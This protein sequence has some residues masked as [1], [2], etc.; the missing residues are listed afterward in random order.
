MPKMRVIFLRRS[1]ALLLAL[2]LSAPDAA[3]ALRAVEPSEDSR[4][5]SGMEEA[6]A[7]GRAKYLG[8]IPPDPTLLLQLKSRPSADIKRNSSWFLKALGGLDAWLGQVDGDRWGKYIGDLLQAWVEDG[9]T[10]VEGYQ[11]ASSAWDLQNKDRRFAK[12]PYAPADAER[13]RTEWRRRETVAT[14]LHDRFSIAGRLLDEAHASLT[15]AM[16]DPNQAILYFLPFRELQNQVADQHLVAFEDEQGIYIHAGFVDFVLDQFKENSREG[17]RMLAALLGHAGIERVLLQAQA[18]PDVSHALA[19]GLERLLLDEPLPEPGRRASPSGLD[20]VVRRFFS[21]QYG[22]TAN[23]SVSAV[24]PAPSPAPTEQPPA[25][26]PSSGKNVT[27][28]VRFSRLPMALVNPDVLR[29]LSPDT[30]RVVQAYVDFLNSHSLQP[31]TWTEIFDAIQNNFN[32]DTSRMEQAVEEAQRA[33][34]ASLLPVFILPEAR[35]EPDLESRREALRPFLAAYLACLIQNNGRLQ[36]S[37]IPLPAGLHGFDPLR[38]LVTGTLGQRILEAVSPGSGDSRFITLLNLIRTIR[39]DPGTQFPVREVTPASAPQIP[40][41]EQPAKRPTPGRSA[42]PPAPE[43]SPQKP[44]GKLEDREVLEAYRDLINHNRF[45]LWNADGT[46]SSRGKGPGRTWSLPYL[47]RIAEFINER[48]TDLS[49]VSVNLETVRQRWNRMISRKPDYFMLTAPQST[50]DAAGR[51]SASQFFSAVMRGYNNAHPD[52]PITSST[53][54]LLKAYRILA[55]LEKGTIPPG[56][57]AALLPALNALFSLAGIPVLQVDFPA[58]APTPPQKPAVP[59]PTPVQPPAPAP[60]V[61]PAPAPTPVPPR[62]VPI[63]TRKLTLR[64]VVFP[65]VTPEQARQILNASGSTPEAE[66]SYVY[67]VYLDEAGETREFPTVSQLHRAVNERRIGTGESPWDSKTINV[68][69]EKILRQVV[70]GDQVPPFYRIDPNVPDEIRKLLTAMAVPRIP[71]EGGLGLDEACVPIGWDPEKLKSVVMPKKNQ[72]VLQR[73]IGEQ[74]PWLTGLIERLISTDE[75]Q[76]RVQI[77][78]SPP[79][80]PVSPAPAPTPVPP[81]PAAPPPAA[82]K[83]TAPPVPVPPVSP[84]SVPPRAVPP[85]VSPKPAAPPP[86]AP[87]SAPTPPPRPAVPVPAVPVPAPPPEAAA[88]APA[89]VPAQ[90]QLLPETGFPAKPVNLDQNI[91]NRLREIFDQFDKPNNPLGSGDWDELQ[92]GT[93]NMEKIFSDANMGFGLIQAGQNSQAFRELMSLLFVSLLDRDLRQYVKAQAS[94][95][96][97]PRWD[98]FLLQIEAAF[99]SMVPPQGGNISGLLK[100]RIQELNL[101]E[102]FTEIL[103]RKGME[104]VFPDA[105]STAGR[106]RTYSDLFDRIKTEDPELYKMLGAEKELR[107]AMQGIHNGDLLTWVG[108]SA[109]IQLETAEDLLGIINSNARAVMS[110]KGKGREEKAS[111]GHQQYTAGVTRVE[112]LQA[113]LARLILT[114]SEAGAIFMRIFPTGHEREGAV[115]QQVSRQSSQSQRR[116]PGGGVVS[117]ADHGLWSALNQTVMVEEVAVQGSDGRWGIRREAYQK[118]FWENQIN[119]KLNLKKNKEFVRRFLKSTDFSRQKTLERWLESRGLK[120]EGSSPKAGLEQELLKEQLKAGP[121]FLKGYT[122][123]AEDGTPRVVPN[124]WIEKDAAV[125]GKAEILI[126]L[127]PRES[128][129]VGEEAWR[130]TLTLLYSQVRI[131]A[132]VLPPGVVQPVPEDF[133]EASESGILDR[134]GDGDVLV[135]DSSLVSAGEER[136]WAPKGNPA[137]IRISP[138]AMQVLIEAGG[139]RA[140]L[141]LIQAGLKARENGMVLEIE[142]AAVQEFQG[143]SAL[144]LTAV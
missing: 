34:A 67:W 131:P 73:L 30:K 119:S 48:K 100:A 132:R 129:P 140:V 19:E 93:I 114:D 66:V 16:D 38:E 111:E 55:L 92:T 110:A 44:R 54:E 141:D 45:P 13:L 81:R 79:V 27:T 143:Y 83:P 128:A 1:L 23:V 113:R 59:T 95:T 117:T 65:R 8:E 88:P 90:S 135:L 11:A 62:S 106:G 108:L 144:V 49:Q 82:P 96:E 60:L 24:P 52:A 18:D 134:I 58:P 70:P 102:I 115:I 84:A 37:D 69:V 133:K 61:S 104:P 32:G 137:F 127:E 31:P 36:D 118:K 46:L 87:V 39:V 4:R 98:V 123:F 136:R 109:N 142:N 33:S 42:A 77:I 15:R 22:R 29:G 72:G 124:E 28:L 53:G 126:S 74:D 5:R 35:G 17:W 78:Q 10:A 97:N 89:P 130:E 41:T 107:K 20:G 105:A 75:R 139:R 91:Y 80:Q 40:P 64:Q 71:G 26:E 50:Q 85:P 94:Y 138:I 14:A 63:V 7:E 6:L 99:G 12:S 47:T 103:R 116:S 9:H 125:P 121:V 112:R 56:E 57:A 68:A 25:A 86:A 2:L 120:V 122:F 43:P 76:M 101:A 21:V 51:L 3:L